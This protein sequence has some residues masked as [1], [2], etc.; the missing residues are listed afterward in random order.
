MNTR[1][2]TKQ[3]IYAFHILAFWALVSLIILTIFLYIYFV[4]Q[5]IFHVAERSQIEEQ[6]AETKSTISE[7]E[8]A[9]I[10]KSRALTRE[11]AMNRG[12][13]QVNDVVFVERDPSTRVSFRND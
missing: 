11:Y 7:N 10:N 13:T 9:L 6:I 3:Q 1:T 2:Y 5:A 8:L 12:F 4:N